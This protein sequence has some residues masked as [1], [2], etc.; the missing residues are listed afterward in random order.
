MDT[1][2]ESNHDQVNRQGR[3]VGNENKPK[4]SWT[5]VLDSNIIAVFW[6]MILLGIGRTFVINLITVNVLPSIYFSPDCKCYSLLVTILIV[7]VVYQ[8]VLDY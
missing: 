7:G 1:T 5:S 2:S 3:T 4:E 8:T 6:L